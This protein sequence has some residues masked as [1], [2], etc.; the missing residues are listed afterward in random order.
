MV[1]LRETTASPL[2]FMK[3]GGGLGTR[4]VSGYKVVS[5]RSANDQRLPAG[6][7]YTLWVGSAR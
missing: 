6:C 1:W 4:L 7:T 3:A 2:F 5:C